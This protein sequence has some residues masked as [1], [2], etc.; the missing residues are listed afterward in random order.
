[1]Y[2]KG[3]G[4]M[5]SKQ[6]RTIGRMVKGNLGFYPLFLNKGSISILLI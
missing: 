5:S 3:A 4:K 6:E 2:R 1:M